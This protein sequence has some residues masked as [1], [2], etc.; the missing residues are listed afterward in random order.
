[1]EKRMKKIVVYQ[2]GTGFTAK[3]AIWIAESLHCEAVDR[4]KISAEELLNY[5]QVIY[6][7]WIMGN[8]IAGYDKIKQMNLKSV[9][10]YAVGATPYSDQ[11]TQAISQQNQITDIPFFYM[12][13]GID[14]KK[15]GFFKRGMLKMVS[16]SIAKKENKTEQDQYMEKALTSSFD[17]TDQKKAAP[18]VEYCLLNG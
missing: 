14:Q 18:L 9:V 17:L 10:V 12:E 6:G 3:Y 13:G 1:M 4:K 8:M 16:K 2:S 5:D 7:G 11:V 15:L